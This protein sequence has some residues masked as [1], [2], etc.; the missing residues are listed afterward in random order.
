MKQN[1]INAPKIVVNRNNASS[2][3]AT[4]LDELTDVNIT[5]PVNNDNLVFDETTSTWINQQ[6]TPSFTSFLDLTDTPSSYVGEGDK[7]LFVNS[8]STGIEF[9]NIH[10]HSNLANLNTIDQ[11]LNSADKPTFAGVALT[12]DLLLDEIAT[13]TTPAA[14]KNKLYFKNDTQL[15]KLDDGGVE[16]ALAVDNTVVHLAGSE[17]ITGDKTFTG[18]VTTDQES[19]NVYSSTGVAQWKVV[20][21][22][23]DYA[24]SLIPDVSAI[25]ATNQYPIGLAVT[26]INVTSTGKVLQRGRIEVTGFSTIGCSVG[27]RVYCDATGSLTLTRTDIQVG[28]VL[29]AAV[30]GIIYINIDDFSKDVIISDN[31]YVDINLGN[32]TTGNGSLTR[33]F[34]TIQKAL[35]EIGQPM[36]ATQYQRRSVVNI[37]PGIYV[38]NLEIPVG[39]ITLLGRGVKIDGNVTRYVSD[40]R[41]FGIDSSTFRSCL[42]LY[43]ALDARMTHN[44]LRQGMHLGGSYR[45]KVY[46][47]NIATIVGDGVTVTVTT[48]APYPAVVGIYLNVTGTVGFNGTNRIINSVLGPNSFTYL[49]ATVG[50]E[51][52]GSF[53]E[54]DIAGATGT[55]HDTVLVNSYACTDGGATWTEDD[56]TVN[57]AAPTTGINI[58]YGFASRIYN[59]VEGR[60]INLYQFEKFEF[61]NTVLVA[62]MT[63]MNDVLF[64]NNITTNTL[65]YVFGWKN[66]TFAPITFTVNNAGQ[67]IYVDLQTQNQIIT[68]VT[69]AGNTPIIVPT[70]PE[71]IN[72]AGF[73]GFLAP[74]DNTS[75]KCFDRIDAYLGGR[76]LVAKSIY[77]STTG[78]DVTGVGTLANPYF[79]IHRALHDLNVFIVGVEVT[80]IAMDGVY[81][82]S[83]L[84]DILIEEK[85]FKG[86][87]FGG[88]L[89]IKPNSSLATRF[90]VLDSGTFDNNPDINSNVHTCTGKTWTAGAYVGK[91][92]RVSTMN[93]GSLP[94]NGDGVNYTYRV[95]PIVRNGIDWIETSYSSAGSQ[96]FGAFDVVEHKVVFD[97]GT[98]NFLVS[99]ESMGGMVFNSIGIQTTGSIFIQQ[100]VTEFAVNPPYQLIAYNS[101]FIG[102]FIWGRG[103]AFSVSYIQGSSSIDLAW[104]DSN[105][106]ASTYNV[107]F[108]KISIANAV[109]NTVWINNSGNN[110]GPLV[111][112]PESRVFGVFSGLHKFINSTSAIQVTADMDISGTFS[113]ENV[114]LFIYTSVSD[115]LH[116]YASVPANFQMLN[117]PSIGRLSINGTTESLIYNDLN[118]DFIAT[119]LAPTA[120][121]VTAASQL[122]NDSSIG[123]TKIKDALNTIPTI[124]LP[125]T[126]FNGLT[127]VSVSSSSPLLPNVGDIWI[128]T[129]T[130]ITLFT[131]GPQTLTS[132]DY[133]VICNSAGGFTVNL[134]ISSTGIIGQ[135]Y[136]IKN[137]GTG[138]ISLQADVNIDSA[139]T[140]TI[141]QWVCL[142]V[143]LIDLGAA[144]YIWVII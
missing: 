127:K 66:C 5:T 60:T 88:R 118:K 26:T 11:D 123:G 100:G 86:V 98:K 108:G 12:S 43:G 36:N 116:V 33:P 28:T 51:V 9:R 57:G 119:I 13:P 70:E 56:G 133:D 92:I 97:L 52:V 3:G 49:N 15:Y 69:W 23:G 39:A 40:S 71:S 102:G 6:P 122:N 55:T 142:T 34:A 101:S 62:S 68:N 7:A 106:V 129:S 8:T 18:D 46:G 114:S 81:D 77:I 17:T 67:S 84:D 78:D 31:Y 80:I 105:V 53:V 47:A 124:T 113:F 143:R 35:D 63:S 22:V 16:V 141:N 42:T 89:R 139:T 138:N 79:S 107:S 140:A 19:T 90:T 128:D 73:T 121:D 2:P 99:D 21:A 25:T 48:T 144:T 111:Y 125:S 93:S 136:N 137:I 117:E 103:T 65:T 50:S 38:E 4:R 20:R 115:D 76:E 14:N 74:T 120:I 134:P 82:W 91:F 1:Y 58:T 59:A 45:C 135:T 132:N 109:R 61:S 54:S 24:S 75:Q 96:N 95:L 32:N 94:S 30:N 112:I 29:V 83:A 130:G 87:T 126:A 85:V 110:T 104:M 41:E 131:S 64:S 27:D 72:S 44:R 37:S 10:S